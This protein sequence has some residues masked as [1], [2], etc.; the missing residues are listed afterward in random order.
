MFIVGTVFPCSEQPGVGNISLEE[1]S[2]PY[3]GKAIEPKVIVANASEA[4]SADCYTV[5][6]SNNVNPGTATATVTLK[7][8]YYEGSKTLNFTITP[9]PTE[10]EPTKPEPV[11]PKPTKPESTPAPL[12][13]EDVPYDKPIDAKNAPTAETMEKLILAN[14]TDEAPAGSRFNLLQLRATKV[15]KKSIKIQWTAVKGA[16][17]YIIYGAKCGEKYSKLQ[18]ITTGS[19]KSW[20]QKKLAKGK[21]YKYFI[22]ATQ[23]YNGS[24]RVIA[25][26]KTIHI[27]T[28]GGKVGNFKSVKLT[29]PKKTKIK[30]K[31]G[32]SLKIKGKA[33]AASKKLKPKN[34][35]KLQYESTNPAIAEVSK[36]GKITAKKAGTCNVYV[37]AQNGVFKKIKVTVKK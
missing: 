6:Y 27:A 36:K 18:V 28:S 35:R 20:T 37:Y 21:Y 3:T 26:S 32:K 4:L 11:K 2:F 16:T 22:V 23:K 13:D 24:D 5:T 10:P 29:N 9:A 25:S 14:S 19:T 7:G 15:T 17:G 12:K 33:V 31:V 30:L 1:D 34:H 8:D